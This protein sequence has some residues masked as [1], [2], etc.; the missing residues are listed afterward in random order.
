MHIQRYNGDNLYVSKSAIQLDKRT[1]YTEIHCRHEK[2]CEQ[3]TNFL[4]KS[5]N[6]SYKCFVIDDKLSFISY[7]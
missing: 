4:R 3:P 5:I 7:E 6:H 1:L 2:Y